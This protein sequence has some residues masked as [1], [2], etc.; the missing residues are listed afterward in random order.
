LA[1]H[2]N[3]V[4]TEP[5]YLSTLHDILLSTEL[6]YLSTLH[7]ILFSTEPLYLSALH[8][9]LLP[10]R[11]ALSKSTPHFIIFNELLSISLR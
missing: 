10:C 8:D 3:L 2:D 9:T 11:D 6:L 7:D 4:S 1:L 5:L